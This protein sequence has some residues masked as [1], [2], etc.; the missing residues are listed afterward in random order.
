MR[1]A[2]TLEMIA[3]DAES[4]D[5]SVPILCGIAANR[6]YTALGEAAGVVLE[7]VDPPGATE[8]MLGGVAHA[9]TVWG[10]DPVVEEVLPL[11][12]TAQRELEGS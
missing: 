6:L 3:R 12:R 1:H 5:A 11:V 9:L 10:A 4:V 2:A 7:F 8:T